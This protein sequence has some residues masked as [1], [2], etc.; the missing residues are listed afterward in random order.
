MLQSLG[1][2]HILNVRKCVSEE[3]VFTMTIFGVVY[4]C[5]R[6]RERVWIFKKFS[7]CFRINF[8][9]RTFHHTVWYG[10]VL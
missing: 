5:E 10:M 8:L 3:E 6:E 2:S 9:Y 7:K 4:I 1:F